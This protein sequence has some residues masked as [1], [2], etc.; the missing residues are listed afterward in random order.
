M[1]PTVPRHAPAMSPTITDIASVVSQPPRRLMPAASTRDWIEIKWPRPNLFHLDL[2]GSVAAARRD[3]LLHSWQALR[4]AFVCSGGALR[5]AQAVMRAKS[6]GHRF[7][8]VTTCGATYGLG[9][10]P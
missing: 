4:V 6:T 9:L 2:R 7:Q 5:A 3:S 8:G 10:M 1:T